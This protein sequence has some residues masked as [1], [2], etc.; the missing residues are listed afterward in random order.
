MCTEPARKSRL[1]EALVRSLEAG[2][3][4]WRR[5]CAAQR[6]EVPGRPGRPELVHPKQV[7]RRR[8]GNPEGRKALIHA[9]AHIEFNAINLA[10]DAVY[11]FAGMPRAFYS[12]W[13]GVAADESRHFSMLEQRLGELGVDYGDYPAHNGLWEM[14]L[15]T[16]ADCLER[17][18]LVPRV[19]EARGLDVTPGMIERLQGA[20]DHATVSVLRIILEEEVGHVEIGSRWFRWCCDEQGREPVATFKT[21]METHYQGQVKRPFNCPARRRAGFSEDELQMLKGMAQG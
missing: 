16:D 9:V 7:P 14:A 15:K 12:D 4:D 17:M 1:V 2:G 6:I 21:L 5:H 10:L 18:A 11:R 19:L 13:L 3:L 8:L 20:G